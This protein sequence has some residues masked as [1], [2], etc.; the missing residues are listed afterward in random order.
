MFDKGQERELRHTL[1]SRRSGQCQV[2]EAGECLGCFESSKEASVGG[3]D[4]VRKNGWEKSVCFVSIMGRVSTPEGQDPTVFTRCLSTSWA[5]SSCGRR[6]GRQVGNW[7][8]QFNCHAPGDRGVQLEASMKQVM[9]RGQ[10][11]LGISWKQSQLC[12]LLVWLK[13]WRYI[14]REVKDDSEG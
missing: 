12:S 7:G 10:M 3:K 14:K 13:G 6:D 4:W 5:D 11:S 8:D 1:N 2:P 9:R